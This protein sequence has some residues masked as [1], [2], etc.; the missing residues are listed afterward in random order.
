MSVLFRDLSGLPAAMLTKAGDL[1]A[2]KPGRPNVLPSASEV[3]EAVEVIMAARA[4][5]QRVVIREEARVVIDGG[6]LRRVS[7]DDKAISYALINQRQ[8]AEGK[9]MFFTATGD[10]FM[11]APGEPR[12]VMADGTVR[13]QA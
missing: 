12:R 7:L 3:V 5:K 1:I 8:R 11:E 6:D 2:L 10:T 13:V 4:E 9:R